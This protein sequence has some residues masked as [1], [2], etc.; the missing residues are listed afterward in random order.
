MKKFIETMKEIF[1]Y[2]TKSSFKDLLKLLGELLV[3]ILIITAFKLPFIMIRDF[4]IEVMTSM[5]FK[6]SNIILLI[7]NLAFD[8]SYLVIGLLIFI[9]IINKRYENINEEKKDL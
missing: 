1:A 6:F 2:C 7:W 4:G 3:I 8:L 9:N 5:G